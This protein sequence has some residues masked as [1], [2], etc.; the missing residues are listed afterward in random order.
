M[1]Y[2]GGLS[3]DSSFHD[4]RCCRRNGGWMGICMKEWNSFEEERTGARRKALVLLTDMDRTEKGLLEK[5][6]K[7]GFSPE[8]AKD[9]LEYVRS[10]GYIDDARYAEHYVEVMQKKRS[11]RRM[12]Y[13]LVRKGVPQE[14]IDAAM[15]TQGPED[16]RPLIRELAEKKAKHMDLSNPKDFNRLA[17]F[18]SRRGFRSEDILSVLSSLGP[19]T[20]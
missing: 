5:L 4:G 10:Y 13:D 20:N 14:R 2:T 19:V 1:S 6:Q 18:L 8:A 11:R 17:A 16:E 15:D 9:A 12:E 7:S 3:F